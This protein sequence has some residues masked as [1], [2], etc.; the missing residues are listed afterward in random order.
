MSYPAS[1]SVMSLDSSSPQPQGIHTP[2]STRSPSFAQLHLPP[3]PRTSLSSVT[4]GHDQDTPRI[5]QNAFNSAQQ[6]SQ[7]YVPIGVG[8]SSQPISASKRKRNDHA[9]RELTNSP[10]VSGDYVMVS[11]VSKTAANAKRM[12]TK[13]SK[14]PAASSAM[15]YHEHYPHP[16]EK[17]VRKANEFVPRKTSTGRKSGGRSLGMHLAPEKAAKA[18]E[19]R[20]DGACWICCLQ[21]DSVSRVYS[22]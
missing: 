17:R 6:P 9:Q 8:T 18:K 7:S 16:D 20:G 19:L 21:R 2:S 22:Q 14:A 13:P 1:V 4:Y 10:S 11:S 3:S 5:P 12:D 15:F